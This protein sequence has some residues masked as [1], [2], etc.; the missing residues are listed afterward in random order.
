ME[1]ILKDFNVETQ[2]NILSYHGIDSNYSNLDMFSILDTPLII[3]NEEDP[4]EYPTSRELKRLTV[5]QLLSIIE[6]EEVKLLT[7]KEGE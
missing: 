4:D 5:Q 6:E 7:I 1:I 3:D 2:S